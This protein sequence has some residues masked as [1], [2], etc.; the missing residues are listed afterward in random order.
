MSFR[1]Q[2]WSFKDSV[3]APDADLGGIDTWQ[4]DELT[5]VTTNA[6][7]LNSV[8]GEDGETE[9]RCDLCKA[10]LPV[11]VVH[12]LLRKRHR[13]LSSVHIHLSTMNVLKKPLKH[14]G[15][16][17]RKQTCGFVFILYQLG[18]ASF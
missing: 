2:T 6:F 7:E 4:V 11:P 1:Q 18:L 10:S 12:R 9:R 5:A 16:P 14:R 13:V 8:L 17:A 15:K 3:Y